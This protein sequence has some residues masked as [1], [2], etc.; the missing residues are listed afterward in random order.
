MSPA[1]APA[2]IRLDAELSDGLVP[3]MLPLFSP[4]VPALPATK[5]E[6]FRLAAGFLGFAA[7]VQRGR[8]GVTGRRLANPNGLPVALFRHSD[9]PLARSVRDW[10]EG[11]PFE[12]AEVWPV[13]RRCPDATGEVAERLLPQ[14]PPGGRATPVQVHHF[15]CH[16]ES[17]VAPGSPQLRLK[18]EGWR[19]AEQSVDARDLLNR[20]TDIRAA[21]AIGGAER[22]D[23]LPLV[24]LNA[25]ASAAVDPERIG[26]F[27]ETFDHGFAGLIATDAIIPEP[28][29]FQF[30]R[31]F[32]EELL[33]GATIGEAIYRSRWAMLK[34]YSN[35]L[36][37]L[38]G[39]F[40][41]PDIRVLHPVRAAA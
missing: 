22:I 11:G 17:T 15:H 3:E 14:R 20:L 29:A 18:A 33:G 16:C 40:A 5:D 12:L 41:D 31:T 39:L 6:L 23:E 38:Y 34:T 10:F 32:Y 9:L 1:L 21:R 13:E 25:C 4:L 28:F 30:S 35:P 19:A 8:A 7:I 27:V 37:L 26:S 2:L 24:F 36:G